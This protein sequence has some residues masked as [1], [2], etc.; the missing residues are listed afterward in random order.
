MCMM[1]ETDGH[2]RAVTMACPM[3][4]VSPVSAGDER[5]RGEIK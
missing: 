5:R 4:A 3:R 1:N 2:G